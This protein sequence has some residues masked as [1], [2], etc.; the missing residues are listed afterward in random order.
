MK[1]LTGYLVVLAFALAMG[2]RTASDPPISG[3]KKTPTAH[4]CPS[5]TPDN[6]ALG[7]GSGKSGAV[8]RRVPEVQTRPLSKL[9][10][11]P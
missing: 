6:P 9:K 5:V 4:P 1:R 11:P 7:A 3:A 10:N 8:T 2:G